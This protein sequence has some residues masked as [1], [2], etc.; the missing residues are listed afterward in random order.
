MLGGDDHNTDNMTQ[1]HQ[2]QQQQIHQLVTEEWMNQHNDNGNNHSTTSYPSLSHHQPQPSQLPTFLEII[3][4]NETESY[5]HAALTNFIRGM[6]SRFVQP[7]LYRLQQQQQQQ[8]ILQEHY[9]YDPL[10][11]SPTTKTAA[12]AAAATTT[13]KTAKTAVSTNPTIKC[14]RQQLYQLYRNKA[15]QFML[16]WNI[17]LNSTLIRILAQWDTIIQFN[18]MEIQY[19][20]R[21]ILERQAVVRYSCTLCEA[22]YGSFVRKKT[23][24][25][26]NIVGT[27]TTPSTRP[28]PP[29]LPLQVPERRI[30]L[31]ALTR[32]DQIRLVLVQT[33]IG[34][35][36]EKIQQKHQQQQPQQQEQRQPTQWHNIKLI[37][38]VLVAIYKAF[39]VYYQYQY[40]IGT[41]YYSN[42]CNRLLKQIL[43]RRQQLQPQQQQQSLPT[44]PSSSPSVATNTEA[45][46]NVTSRV[47]PIMVSATLLLCYG[48]QIIHWY[49]QRYRQIQQEQLLLQQQQQ[50]QEE[51]EVERDGR[52]AAYNTD[53]TNRYQERIAN[54]SSNMGVIPVPLLPKMSIMTS[55]S[56]GRCPICNQNINDLN[57]KNHQNNENNRNRTSTTAQRESS[58]VV[59]YGYVYCSYSCIATYLRRHDSTCPIT[60]NRVNV[61]TQVIRLL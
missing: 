1:Q 43:V 7:I 42:V 55:L 27:S 44:V 40:L 49:S 52:T 16:R 17:V 39:N 15:R 60:G 23:K 34:Y 22:I 48:T 57:N 61:E 38:S 21:Y 24:M 2:Q 18:T 37:P 50:Q 36:H 5:I 13:K 25:M 35:L 4:M 26:M 30:Q 11:E 54:I 8:H 3:W 28:A 6:Q 33:M 31:R 58:I 53:G 20:L 9:N 56:H 51:E 45:K 14:R 19:I 29:A 10:Y 41:S 46:M 59:L 47:L 12:A 32:N